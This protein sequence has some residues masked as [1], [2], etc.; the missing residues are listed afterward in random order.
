[1]QIIGIAG[2]A[3]AG[4]TTCA[5]FIVGTKMKSLGM[6]DEFKIDENGKLFVQADEIQDDDSIINVSRE[7]NAKNNVRNPEFELWAQHDLWP[8]VKVY[9]LADPLKFFMMDTF[10]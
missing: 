6:I 1:V 10:G 5:N 7:F 2:S 8:H 9:S 3:R 4:K